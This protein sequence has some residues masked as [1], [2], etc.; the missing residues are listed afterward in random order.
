[1]KV[2]LNIKHKFANDC[3]S[4]NTKGILDEKDNILIYSEEKN[5]KVKFFLSENILLRETDEMIMELNFINDKITTSKIYLKKLRQEMFLK[6]KTLK[7]IC[8]DNIYKIV[9]QIENDSPIEYQV[10]LIK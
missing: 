7:I 1:M 6:I 9:Y 3:I 2:N 10:Q 8:E 5:T 4:F